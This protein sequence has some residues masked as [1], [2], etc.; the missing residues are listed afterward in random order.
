MSHL[1][2]NHIS[3]IR[4]IHLFPTVHPSIIHK[5]L[6]ESNNQFSIALDKLSSITNN[7]YPKTMVPTF[8]K[9][10]F[11]AHQNQVRNN[12]T[13]PQFNR[14]ISNY[15]LKIP[16][17][18]SKSPTAKNLTYILPKYGTEPQQKYLIKPNDGIPKG[19][20]Y[21]HIIHVLSTTYTYFFNLRNNSKNVIYYL[22]INKYN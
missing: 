20:P 17:I 5:I 4:L 18:N 6:I 19:K 11:P 12:C 8:S 22:R 21:I 3:R 13:T 7:Y 9:N 15:R 10:Y 14:N 16:I 2:N 1:E